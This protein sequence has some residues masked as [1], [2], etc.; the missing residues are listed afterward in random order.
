[1]KNAEK[2]KN[3]MTVGRV[4]R[5]Q[6]LEHVSRT[7]D[8]DLKTLVNSGEVERLAGGLYYRPKRNAFGA[9]PPLERELVRAF[10]KTDDFLVTSHTYFN[11][12]GLGLTQV[13][14]DCVVYNHARKGYFNLGGRRFLFRCPRSYPRELSKEFL[15]VDLLNNL[16]ELP[17]NTDN[18]VE[19]L[20]RRLSEFDADKVEENLALY[21]RAR[22]R[23]ALHQAHA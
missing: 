9:V 16:K 19:N 6:E 21:G 8:R 13:Y 18:V 1:M 23:E 22:A 15:L 7:P 3:A 20:K 2:L 11:Q 14:N 10:L 12:L 4:Y 17:E 5:R